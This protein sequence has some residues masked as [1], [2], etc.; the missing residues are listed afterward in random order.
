M[1]EEIYQK[2]KKARQSET[3]KL[4]PNPYLKDEITKPDG[5]KVP[6]KLRHYQ[7]QMI[8]HMLLT[9]KFVV[10]DDTGL[11][12][13]AEAIAALCYMW[14]KEPH[15]KP[16]IITNTSAMRQW[17]GEI[18]KFTN[19]VSWRLVEGGPEDREE[20]YESYFEEW[21]DDHPEFLIVNYHRLR[22]DHRYFLELMEDQSLVV[23]A[24]EA[25]AFKNPDSKTHHIMRKICDKAE[26]SYGLTATLIKNELMEGYGIY[27][28]LAPKLFASKSKFMRRYCVTR[29]QK[30][31]GS[32]RKIPIVVGHSQKHIKKFKEKIDPYYLGRPKHAVADELPLLNTKEIFTRMTDTQWSYYKDALN[33]FLTINETSEEDEEEE[34]E[35]THLTQLI[36]TQ[37]IVNS[38]ALI[39]N[40][41][42]STKQE[43]LMDML[44]N[45]LEKEK[46]IVFTRFR[47]MVDE[48][49][50]AVK[51]KFG[52]K[53]A[54]KQDGKDWEINQDPEKTY[55]RITGAEDDAQRDAG[56]R[57]FT[58]T[59]SCD[60]I[61]L[62]MA[63]AEAINLQQARVMVF[64]DMP[65]SAG[66]YL[67]LVGR[68]IR[69]GSPHQ[70]V[71]ALHM[72]SEGPLGED[73]ID[74]HVLKT[75]DKKMKLIEQVIGERVVKGEDPSDEEI[76]ELTSDSKEI[77]DQLKE[78]AYSLKD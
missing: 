33:G 26:R 48:L 70:S 65:W 13:T 57:A 69:I 67:Q 46:V 51:E 15:L 19:G 2:L 31:K 27:K 50:I 62:T 1:K 71:Y 52:Y 42:S 45:E 59:E 14:V 72:V 58:E 76:V 78:Q 55:A 22:R 41:G 8:Y 30:I 39:G 18:D 28:V 11:G 9:K 66:D 53:S 60:L 77:F 43:R 61:F 21:D 10:G 49:E 44:E 64:F 63:G 29:M 56:K 23:I 54:I 32:R 4:A 35:V 25:T 7:V 74:A 68:M 17:G 40:D 34:K 6:F 37:Q 20:I 73:T 12:K 75:L 5:T 16:L 3:M 47:G 38:P 24:D 36:Y